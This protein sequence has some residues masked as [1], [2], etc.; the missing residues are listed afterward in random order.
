MT[1]IMN[2]IMKTTASIICALALAVPAADAQWSVGVQAGVTYNSLHTDSGYAYD[3]HY[4]PA[5]GYTVGIPVRYDFRD[6]FGL[7]AEA[8]MVYRGYAIDRSWVYWPIY[9]N[10]HNLYLDVP[11]FAR[12]SFGGRR[13]RGYALAG[14]YVGAWLRSEVYGHQSR[15]FDTAE[16]NVEGGYDFEE[17]VPFDS[18]R[19][20]RFDAGLAA[21]I[22]IS[23]A[24]NAKFSI[25][26]EARYYY[27][28]TD[29][30]KD[31]MKNRMPRYNNTLAVQIGGWFTFPNK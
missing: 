6:W 8:T 30:Q 27:G 23:Y 7:Q 16:T 25:F 17:T 4:S 31:Y 15:S 29:M 2:N 18:R 22:G 13:L 14:A 10:Y 20:N 24:F 28:L 19:D 5:L 12:F 26:A 9:Y 11:V 21:G 1:Q 3:R